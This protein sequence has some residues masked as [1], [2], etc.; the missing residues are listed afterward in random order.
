MVTNGP[1]T[2]DKVGVLLTIS[3]FGI[4]RLEMDINRKLTRDGK[5]LSQLNAMEKLQDSYVQYTSLNDYA[6]ALSFKYFFLD[7]TSL[8]L[9]STYQHIL[10]Q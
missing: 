9:E 5:F 6:L 3:R 1:M 7:K 4:C 10:I 2:V 8:T